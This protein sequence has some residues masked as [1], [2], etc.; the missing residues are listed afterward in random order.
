[1]CPHCVHATNRLH[2]RP[3][4]AFTYHVRR[5]FNR[6]QRTWAALC[7]KIY[8]GISN[9]TSSITSTQQRICLHWLAFVIV[10]YLE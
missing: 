6:M 8:S 4:A 10:V 2:L 5:Q 1:M 7:G 3:K 9:L